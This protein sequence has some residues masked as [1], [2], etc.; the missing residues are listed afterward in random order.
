MI[1]VVQLGWFGLT[2]YLVN[3]AGDHKDK[4]YP[5]RRRFSRFQ[6]LLFAARR[7]AAV[8]GLQTCVLIE[9]AG[10]LMLCSSQHGRFNPAA[11]HHITAAGVEGAP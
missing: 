6:E 10:D 1:S 11:L 8:S 4:K 5:K 3:I 9:E 7:Y 2:T